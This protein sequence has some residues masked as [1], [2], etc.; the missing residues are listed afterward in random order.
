M[1]L[2]V[3]LMGGLGNQM[4]QYAKGLSALEQAPQYTDLILDC[5]FYEGQ[6]RKV[7]KNGLTGRGFDLDIFN[8]KYKRCEVAPVGGHLL[9]G[10]FQSLEDFDNVIGQVKEQFTFA[11]PFS[12]KIQ[13]MNDII[14]NDPF[15]TVCIHVRRGDFINNPTAFAHNEHM[16]PEYYRKAMDVME[17]KYDHLTYF[18]FSEDE[19]WCRE[20]IKNDK[21][22]VI[23]IGNDYAGDRDTGHFHLMQRCENHII[24]NSTYSWWA[25]FLGD[26]KLTVGPKKWFTHE[27]SSD[28][29]LDDWIKL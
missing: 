22:P 17:D 2:Y 1:N 3:K 19:E 25:A 5:S 7:I 13:Q 29:M 12:K 21:H 11:N 24:A 26:S 18:V 6:E 28:I 8:I 4:F 14:T 23:V 16:G 15:H 9:E 27:N 10:W 20:N